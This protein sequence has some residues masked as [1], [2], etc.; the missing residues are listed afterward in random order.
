MAT[1]AYSLGLLADRTPFVTPAWNAAGPRLLN[2]PG[3]PG[4][5]G[6]SRSL[7]AP[8][9]TAACNRIDNISA[10]PSVADVQVVPSSAA[11]SNRLPN[12]PAKLRRA[13]SHSKPPPTSRA[14]P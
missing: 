3:P 6:R 12:A 13:R 14:P 10:L 11:V 2:E 9:Q 1:P 4:A 5:A 7:T 8:N